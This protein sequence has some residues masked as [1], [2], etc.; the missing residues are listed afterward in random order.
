MIFNL[1]W[2][3]GHNFIQSVHV[4]AHT[5]N[6]H[7]P[8]RVEGAHCSSWDHRKKLSKELIEEEKGEGSQKKKEKNSV[9][10]SSSQI[11]WLPAGRGRSDYKKSAKNRSFI[12]SLLLLLPISFWSWVNE[13]RTEWRRTHDNRESSSYTLVISPLKLS[14]QKKKKSFPR[15]RWFYGWRGGSE[16]MVPVDFLPP[17]PSAA[18]V[19]KHESS[20]SFD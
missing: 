10:A 11:E 13:R 8:Y 17:L 18:A 5:H 16:K 1:I 7:L 6:S 4:N 3:N 19:I 15:Q 2:I 14:M 12:F 9:F 20:P